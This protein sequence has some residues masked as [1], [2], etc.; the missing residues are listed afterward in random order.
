MNDTSSNSVNIKNKNEKIKDFICKDIS[1]R[2]MIEKT[3]NILKDDK[4][5]HSL[6]I[7]KKK[8]YK[9]LIKAI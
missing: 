7:N 2:R 4:Q 1:T 6:N 3:N 5:K 8:E 9:I